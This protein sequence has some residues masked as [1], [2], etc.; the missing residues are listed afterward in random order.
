[1]GR[2]PVDAAAP[3]GKTWKAIDFVLL[4]AILAVA[5]WLRLTHID[6]V[7]S[8]DEIWH[9]ETTQGY[10][11]VHSNYAWNQVHHDVPSMTS[12]DHAAPVWAIWKDMRGVLH[13][14]LFLIALRLWR[15]LCG[16]G[17]Y[18]A[19]LFSITWSLF[20]IAF[21]FGSARLA[22]DRW[23]GTLCAAALA[24]AQTQIYF[25][26]EIRAYAMIIGIG[27]AALWLMTRCEVLGVTRRRLVLLGL[28]T[29]L[30]VLSHYLTFGAAVAIGLYGLARAGKHRRI[31]LAVVGACAL[32]Y[33][34][35]WV[36]FALKQ[37][38]E[39]YV[40]DVMIKIPERDLLYTTLMVGATPFRLLAERDFY[41]EL[42]PV[43]SG[44]LF[45]LPWLLLRRFPALLP[46]AIWLTASMGAIVALD[47][48]RTT[49]H[50]SY[51]RYLAIATPAVPLL[52]VGIGWVFRRWL[53]YLIGGIVTF[54]GLIYLVSGNVVIIDAQ[55]YPMVVSRLSAH[56]KPGEPILSYEDRPAAQ[57]RAEVMMAVAGHETG[58]FPRTIAILTEP[59]T[60]ELIKALRSETA[61]LIARS[62]LPEESMVPGARV[63]ESFLIDEDLRLSH[64]ALDASSTGPS[65]DADSIGE[66][67]PSR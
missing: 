66:V 55:S 8:F 32:F 65:D 53:A 9:M 60:P 17:S 61:W 4:L 56:I 20:G 21:T 11:T 13:P 48:V 23:A 24:C 64:L 46:W 40:G 16:D 12:L 58:I 43:L 15:E 10:G 1:M 50:V 57:W 54:V 41:F 52:F 19:H 62:D 49:R 35:A 39:F 5:T 27:A 42:T 63:M 26:Q 7:P 33:L 44:V 34:V 67:A 29:L 59:M 37:T 25:A 28:M 18:A 6:P 45:L 51:I 36:P 3:A 22:M 2:D 14:P 38:H 31:F 47:L 30:L